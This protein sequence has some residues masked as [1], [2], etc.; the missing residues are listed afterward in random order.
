MQGAQGKLA[1]LSNHEP[2]EIDAV[3][4]SV[5][6]RER[7]GWV[8]VAGAK[9]DSGRFVEWRGVSPVPGLYFVGREWMWSRGS[10]LLNG[11]GRDA[12]YVAASIA[13]RLATPEGIS[14]RAPSRARS[15]D[16]ATRS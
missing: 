14:L 3:V 10:G 2:L 12:A 6:Y 5:G 11:V 9:D 16:R 7:T 4:W 15:P 13:E 1:V 8:D